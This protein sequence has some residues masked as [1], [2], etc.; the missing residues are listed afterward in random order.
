MSCVFQ[1][2]III[3]EWMGY[4]LLYESMLDSVLWARDRYLDAGGQLLPDFCRMFVA[5]LCDVEMHQQRCT[6]WDDVYGFRMSCMKSAVISEA[7]ITVVDSSKVIT[8]PCLIKVCLHC[9]HRIIDLREESHCD[10]LSNLL[11]ILLI[12][13][14][15]VC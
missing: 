12:L 13:L 3:S 2:D 15:D 7:E 10:V 8:E 14:S 1:V 5:G 4:F 11:Y 6:F 9:S